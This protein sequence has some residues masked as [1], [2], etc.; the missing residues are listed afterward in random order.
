MGGASTYCAARCGLVAKVC[1]LK[2]LGVRSKWYTLYCTLLQ[3]QIDAFG[4]AMVM[5]NK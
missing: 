2:K 1:T 5:V 4:D 3:D